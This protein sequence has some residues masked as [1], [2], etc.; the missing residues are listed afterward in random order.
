M[1]TK[2]TAF[3]VPV[4]IVLYEFSFFPA[5]GKG[6]GKRLLLLLPVLLTLLIIPFSLVGPDGTGIQEALRATTDISRGDYLLTQFRVIVTYLRLLVFP[7]NQT[8]DYDYP[9][10]RSF[11]DPAVLFSFLFLL[12]LAGAAYWLFFRARR[13]DSRELRL[14]SFGVLW[15]FIALS[16]ESSIIPIADVIFEHRLYLPSAGV[17]LAL[18]T[19]A[20]LAAKRLRSLWP[21]MPEAVLAL[22]LCV[23][24]LLQAATFR[25][26]RVWHSEVDLWEDVLS[27]NPG[28]ARAHAIIGL[29]F[30]ERGGIDAAIEHFRNAILLKPGYAEAHVALGNAY[31]SKGRLDEGLQEYL[32]ALNLGTL[33]SPDTAMLTMNIGT[34]YLG[35]KQPDKAIEYY[36]IALSIAPQDAM[37]HHNLGL[38]YQ[39]KGLKVKA[40]EEFRKAHRLN[41]EKY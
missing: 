12:G 19:A 25:R 23:I 31:V 3:T 24:I 41:P 26:N 5:P 27:K 37:V 11:S 40:E 33:D 34:Y 13:A 29:K 32:T 14:I 35:R 22:A 39:A 7:V 8:L 38:A 21:F 28:H 6:A 16:V 18:A 2:E 4:I 30:I 20:V 9:I 17:F 36:S 15:F 1:K 10:Y